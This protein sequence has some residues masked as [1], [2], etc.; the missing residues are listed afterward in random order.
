MR[1]LRQE[2]FSKIGKINQKKLEKSTVAVIGLGALGSSV[3]EML[4]RAGIKNLI[5]IDRDIIELSNLQRQ[6]LYLE[7]DINKLKAVVAKERLLQIDSKSNIK[8]YSEDLDFSNIGLIKSDLVLDC[9]DNFETRFLIN[10]FCLSKNIPWIYSAVVGSKGMIFNII[11]GEACFSCI[12]KESSQSLGTCETFGILNS[13]VNSIASIQF[14]EAVKILTNQNPSKELIIF[15]VWSLELNKLKVSKNKNCSSCNQNY[16]FLN[17]TSSS[18]VKLSCSR[19]QIKL[20][21]QDLKLLNEKLK[22]LSPTT[23]TDECLFFND[24]IIFKNGRILVKA[25]T[26]ERAKSLVDKYL[27]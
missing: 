17:K 3:S 5:L 12:F 25:E 27:G 14:T 16:K 10:D 7:S 11:P 19:F 15:D 4:V 22:K 26:K 21:P 2:I 1:Y 6:S 20:P 8:S 9:T 13:A 18:L 24:L 23:L